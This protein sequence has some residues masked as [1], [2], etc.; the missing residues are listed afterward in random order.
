M[1]DLEKTIEELEKTVRKLKDEF[2]LLQKC[3]GNPKQM[4]EM[5]VWKSV[6]EGMI[7]NISNA[8]ISQLETLKS[9]IRPRYYDKEYFVKVIELEIL[10]QKRE[11][12]LKRICN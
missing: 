10:R 1:K 12:K 6:E 9:N 11:N 7:K 2:E 4:L 8:S 3:N 5:S